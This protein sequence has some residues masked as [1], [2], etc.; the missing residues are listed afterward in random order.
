[1]KYPVKTMVTKIYDPNNNSVLDTWTSSY[2]S[3]TFTPENYVSQGVQSGDLQQGFGFFY[4]RIG[5]TYLC[6]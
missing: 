3:Y 1:M 2:G 6:Q 4:G 5:F